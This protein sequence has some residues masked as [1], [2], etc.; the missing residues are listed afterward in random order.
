MLDQICAYLK[1]WF[2]RDQPKYYGTFKIEN[3]QITFPGGDMG[4]QQ[5]QYFRVIGS[6]FN[7][8]VWRYGTDQLTDEEFTGAVWLMA[9]PHSLILLA[10]EIDLWQNRYGGVDSANLS[11][12]ASE[13]FGGYSYTKSQ[14]GSASGNAG[15]AVGWESVFAP[16][17]RR[18][19]KL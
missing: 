9:V 17:L 6:V 1:N 5:G 11:P 14:G 18:W 13:S 19:K 16:R 7:D 10:A 15:G 2:D 8:G 3:G 12:Y 4:I